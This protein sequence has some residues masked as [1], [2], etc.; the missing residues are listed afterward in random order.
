MNGERVRMFGGMVAVLGGSV[1]LD[2][3]TSRIRPLLLPSFAHAEGGWSR[4][5]TGV[6]LAIRPLGNPLVNTIQVGREVLMVLGRVVFVGTYVVYA[7]VLFE[8]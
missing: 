7:Q 8:L 6:F 2:G 1:R 5:S 3:C 4:L